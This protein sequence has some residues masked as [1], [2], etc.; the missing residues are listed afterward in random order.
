M[1]SRLNDGADDVEMD[2]IL[3][4]IN[5]KT[6]SNGTERIG[7]INNLFKR[8]IEICVPTYLKYMFY[9][10]LKNQG[11]FEQDWSVIEEKKKRKM[12]KYQLN[13]MKLNGLE[14]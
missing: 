5:S 12:S 2:K 7:T 9:C 11:V 4:N 1:E 13:E 3:D 14:E 6:G 8:I 10:S